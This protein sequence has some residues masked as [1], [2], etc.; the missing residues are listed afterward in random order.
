M[1]AK[2]V[3]DDCF[4]KVDK[5]WDSYT[6][7]E[8]DLAVIHTQSDIESMQQMYFAAQ[9]NEEMIFYFWKNQE[10]LLNM[11]RRALYQIASAGGLMPGI[12]LPRNILFG[13]APPSSLEDL[14]ELKAGNV[15]EHLRF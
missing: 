4:E 10:R 6:L 9:A 15:P 8:N 2:S 13:K 11:Q 5:N 3:H 7:L 12:S 14:L 1:K